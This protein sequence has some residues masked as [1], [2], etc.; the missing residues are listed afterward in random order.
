MTNLLI[1]Q[2]SYKFFAILIKQQG[3]LNMENL[4]YIPHG[5]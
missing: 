4:L 3:T 5:Y 2:Y 1:L